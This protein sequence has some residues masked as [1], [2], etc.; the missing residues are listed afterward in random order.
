MRLIF[1]PSRSSFSLWRAP[2]CSASINSADPRPA[3]PSTIEVPAVLGLSKVG[4]ERLLRNARL[5]PR[6][7]FANGADGTSI[8]T[9]ITQSPDGANT[10][11]IGS[12]VIVMI[13]I[14][15]G[16]D[17]ITARHSGDEDR[18]ENRPPSVSSSDNFRPYCDSGSLDLQARRSSLSAGG[19]GMHRV[20]GGDST[21]SEKA[22]DSTQPEKA[23]DNTQSESEKTG[24]SKKSEKAAKKDKKFSIANQIRRFAAFR[25]QPYRW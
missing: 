7:E 21:Q 10:A 17:A 25:P 16:R 9:V 13:N 20:Q 3:E 11:A 12:T 8:G 5:V 6:F 19:A 23:S 1:L 18:L 24:D 22:S 4:T 15:S 2:A 14:G